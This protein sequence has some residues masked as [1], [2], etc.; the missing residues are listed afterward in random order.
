MAP[1]QVH[2]GK[3]GQ[4]S[5]TSSAIIVCT[6]KFQSTQAFKAHQGACYLSNDEAHR[7]TMSVQ[8]QCTD[9]V[10]YMHMQ[11]ALHQ[12]HAR[13]VST[14]PAMQTW[15]PLRVRA[16]LPCSNGLTSPR[17]ELLLLHIAVLNLT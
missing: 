1:L 5:K 4:K 16:P 9:L 17:W 6:Q 8:V 11:K 13:L 10:K 2:I 15:G 12:L 7:T 14:E 3:G